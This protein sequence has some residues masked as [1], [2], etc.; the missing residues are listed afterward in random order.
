MLISSSAKICN[1]YGSDVSS[2]C[3]SSNKCGLNQG[4]CDSDS[5]CSGNLVCGKNNCRAVGGSHFSS[6]AD[7]CVQPGN[8]KK[9][10]CC[11]LKKLDMFSL[12]I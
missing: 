6:G 11:Q 10:A 12:I 3:S 1:G 2:C 5:D 7:C 8:H 9:M 4:D